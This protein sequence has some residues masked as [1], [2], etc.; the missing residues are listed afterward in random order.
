MVELP[1]AVPFTFQVTLV[2]LDPV[3]VAVNCTL[4][5]GGT[6]AFDGLT[7]TVI[8]L[9]D[10][11]DE[12]LELPLPPPQPWEI[13][14]EKHSAVKSQIE[15]A[16]LRA[17]FSDLQGGISSSIRLIGCTKRCC[18]YESLRRRVARGRLKEK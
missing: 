7:V 16:N 9:D 2:L 6:V 11:L 8:A 13:R 14:T 5:P 4:P 3:T 17:I 18:Q 15:G 10:E 1:P 12:E